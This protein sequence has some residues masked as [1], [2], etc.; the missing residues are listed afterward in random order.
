[1][2]RL[3]Q[4]ECFFGMN[5]VLV[6]GWFMPGPLSRCLNRKELMMFSRLKNA[7]VLLVSRVGALFKKRSAATENRP[8]KD[9]RTPR[10]GQ[11]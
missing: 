8:V 5:A 10:N 2:A 6:L 3:P 7:V 9:E 1:M 4:L 11:S